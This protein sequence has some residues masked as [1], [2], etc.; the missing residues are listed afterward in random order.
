MATDVCEG[1]PAVQRSRGRRQQAEGRGGGG[2]DEKKSYAGASKAIVADSKP[3][4][5]SKKAEG[6]QGRKGKCLKCGSAD[7][8]MADCPDC[9]A[10]EAQ[11]LLNAQIAKWKQE[12]DQTPK[13][14]RLAAAAP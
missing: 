1:V 7:H 4:R 10:A 14:K 5:E 8:K 6:K 3:A 9:D 12:R 2:G 11:R 13:V